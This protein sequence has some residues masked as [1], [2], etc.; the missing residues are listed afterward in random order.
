[1]YF[2]IAVTVA[3]SSSTL[4]GMPLLHPLQA[5]VLEV[6]LIFQGMSK[7]T[8]ICVA[9][10]LSKWFRNLNS[11]TW[12]AFCEV[13]FTAHAQGAPYICWKHSVL[14]CTVAGPSFILRAFFP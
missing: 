2:A 1:M 6:F 10:V 4:H 12:V 13:M 9:C 14:L 7:I 5:L 3:F 8:L 11:G